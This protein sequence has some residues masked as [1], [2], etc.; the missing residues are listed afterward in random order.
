MKLI[1]KP[2]KKQGTYHR[3]QA[4]T[5]L[6]NIHVPVFPARKCV[7]KGRTAYGFADTVTHSQNKNTGNKND[8]RTGRGADKTPA[9]ENRHEYEQ[10]GFFADTV[11][12]PAESDRRRGNGYV[13]EG[14]QNSHYSGVKGKFPG[15]P[16][17]YKIKTAK[18]DAKEKSKTRNGKHKQTPAVFIH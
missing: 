11:R 3:A 16:E 9:G 17:E 4:E 18:F 12:Y 15:Y 10:G 13:L 14:Y 7:R 6:H 2:A 1:E 5:A 8:N